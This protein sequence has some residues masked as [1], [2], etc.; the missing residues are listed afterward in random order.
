VLVSTQVLTTQDALTG[1]AA[2]WA[3]AASPAVSYAIVR[4]PPPTGDAELDGAMAGLQVCGM[5]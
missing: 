1:A 5:P 2:A 4:S 3:L